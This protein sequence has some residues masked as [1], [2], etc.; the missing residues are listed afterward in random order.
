MQR[1]PDEALTRNTVDYREQQRW[2]TEMELA[3]QLIEVMSIPAAGMRLKKQIK[4]PR[5]NR[6]RPAAAAGGQPAGNVVEM[7]P[8]KRAIERMRVAR[9]V[10]R[11]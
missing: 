5:P 8:Y 1:L 10:T 7:D 9:G 11:G 3:A 2:T 4:V 6:N